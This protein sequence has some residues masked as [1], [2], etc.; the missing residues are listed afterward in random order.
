M[1]KIS[2]GDEYWQYNKEN[3][4]KVWSNLPLRLM[5]GVKNKKVVEIGSGYGI[6]VYYL[7][8]NNKVSG[9]EIDDA[10]VESSKKS[11]K[12]LGRKNI[13]IIQ[14]D[15]RKLPYKNSSFDWVFCHGVIEHFNP[16]EKAI[17]EGY[18]IL[19]KG[20]YAMYSVPA[21]IS[22]FVPLKFMQKLADRLLGTN[23]W[24]AGYEKSFTPWKFKRMLR[25]EGFKVIHFEISETPEGRRHPFVGKVLRAMDKLFWKLQIG[26]RFMY[27]V[28]RKEK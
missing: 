19:K 15:A 3:E 27:A 26:G 14:G 25:N 22:F 18:R 5:K 20:G 16:S 24:Q 6:Y 1:K 17:A 11:L 7:S 2:F 4:K 10:R 13:Q 12:K 8:K 23:M 9:I 21:R 28:C